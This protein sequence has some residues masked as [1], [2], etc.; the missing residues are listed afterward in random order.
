MKIYR[1]ITP[2]LA[3]LSLWSFTALSPVAA[4]DRC[5][6]KF[7][8]HNMRSFPITISKGSS[9]RINGNK[10]AYVERLDKKF[11]IPPGQRRTTRKNRLQK[12]DDNTRADFFLD[13]RR[14][15][16]GD[17]NHTDNYNIP[18]MSRQLGYYKPNKRCRDGDRFIVFTLR[19]LPNTAANR[20]AI[21]ART[22]T[23]SNPNASYRSAMKLFFDVDQP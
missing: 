12:V 8:F 2:I 19:P 4:A 3:V 6:I 10:G 20:N 1:I 15:Q 5:N 22:S 23:R 17:L 21:V 7:T 11:V 16:W 13:V 14:T 18:N 9:I